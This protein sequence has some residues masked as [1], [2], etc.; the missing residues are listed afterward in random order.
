MGHL[1]HSQ[2]TEPRSKTNDEKIN[3]TR[4]QMK[5]LNL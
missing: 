5:I 4:K 2:L 1:S 3:L